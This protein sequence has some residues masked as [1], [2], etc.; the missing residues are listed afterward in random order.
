MHQ[1]INLTISVFRLLC[2]FLISCSPSGDYNLSAET[3]QNII[4]FIGDGM[5][6]NHRIAAQWVS[7]GIDGQLDMD[8]MP[9]HGWVATRS[10]DS[11]ITDSAAA[12]TAMACGIKTKNGTIGMDMNFNSVASILEIAVAEGKKVGLVTTTQIAHATPAAFAAHVESRKEMSEIAS[13]MVAAGID[14]MMGGGEN[15]LLPVNQKGCYPDAGLRVD[16]RNLIEE[17]ISDGYKYVC[18]ADE[19]MQIDVESSLRLI[20]VFA[21]EGLTRPFS[22][23][24]SEMTQKAIAILSQGTDGF[25]LMVEAGQID[26]SSH[27]N[28]AIHAIQ[29]ALELNEAVK[30]A[31]KFFKVNPSTLIIVTADHETGGMSLSL[32]P[33]K[34][35]INAES[36]RMPDGTCFYVQWT[37]TGHTG[38]NVPITSWGPLSAMLSGKIENTDIFDVMLTGL[39]VE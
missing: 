21:D 13:Q 30:E 17:A 32:N 34:V 10:A 1:K 33:Q 35:K 9:R 12:S 22:P 28:D 15:D 25:F 31:K 38:Q 2:L 11:D 20:G 4:L 23:S 26:W 6:H 27:Q 18:N 7:M 39:N 5:G 29:S 36:F 19:L 8:D 16:G 3:P 24:L 14:V 37:T